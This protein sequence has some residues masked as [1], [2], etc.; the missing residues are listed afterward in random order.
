MDVDASVLPTTEQIYVFWMVIEAIAA[1]PRAVI[2][3]F[4]VVNVVTL[5]R[6]SPEQQR[7]SLTNL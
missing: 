6:K 7:T 2:D 5:H 4:S 3:I 1:C